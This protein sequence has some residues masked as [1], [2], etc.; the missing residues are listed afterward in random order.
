[1]SFLDAEVGLILYRFV[2]FHLPVGSPVRRRCRLQEVLMQILLFFSPKQA[3]S[4]SAVGF[5]HRS[6]AVFDPVYDS[7]PG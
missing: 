1:M 3:R 5:R 2:Q 4:G 7:E 6:I